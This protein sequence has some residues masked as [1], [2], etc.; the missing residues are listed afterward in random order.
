MRP[1]IRSPVERRAAITNVKRKEE[2]P[3]KGELEQL[4]P[5]PPEADSD[6]QDYWPEEPDPKLEPKIYVA[7]L[8]DYNVGVLH[9]TW[10]DADQEP[11]AMHDAITGMLQ[12]SPTDARA[13]EWAIHD[14]EGFNGLH[15]GEWED[16]EHVSKVAK[17]IREHG[18]AYAHFATIVSADEE[19]DQFEERYLGKWRDAEAYAE[20]VFDDL[21]LFD[22][23]KK[24]VSENLQ[25]YV[26]LD[27]AG[28]A[29]DLVAGGDI[30]VIE[31]DS[32]V[33]IFSNR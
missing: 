3:M 6:P 14:F 30:T 13:E 2:Q 20:E 15:L 11:E 23:V 8:S 18:V 22:E 5:T 27:V 10:I 19:L 1:A 25:P 33:H 26:T 29:R 28:F 16:L 32:G 17:G 24:C 7:S 9:G 21:G 4:Q 12:A 31:A